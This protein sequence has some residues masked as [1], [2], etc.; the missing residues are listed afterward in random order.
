LVNISCVFEGRDCPFFLN[1]G[2][3]PIT[4]F[5]AVVIIIFLQP[6][7]E[8][9]ALGSPQ[10]RNL[11][12]PHDGSIEHFLNRN[13]NELASVPPSSAA[14]KARGQKNQEDEERERWT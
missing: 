6:R 12:S 3:N 1:V 7:D 11:E 8:H 5:R 2:C 10:H 13:P 9:T 14:G 4:D